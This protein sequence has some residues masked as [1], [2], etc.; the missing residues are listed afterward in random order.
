MENNW[1]NEKKPGTAF[2]MPG[3]CERRVGVLGRLES[4]PKLPSPFEACLLRGGILS[5]EARGIPDERE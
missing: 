3:C 2:G 5:R 1:K 4:V